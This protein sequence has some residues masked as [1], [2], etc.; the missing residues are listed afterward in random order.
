[1]KRTE[2]QLVGAL[3]G[4]RQPMDREMLGLQLERLQLIDRRIEKLN[5]L[6]AP[7]VMATS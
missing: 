7:G 3:T 2:E 4:R 6:A 1:M 5:G